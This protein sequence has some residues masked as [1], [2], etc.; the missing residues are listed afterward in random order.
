[1]GLG[2]RELSMNPGSIPKVKD[3]ISHLRMDAAESLAVR[4]LQADSA[5]SARA[6]AQERFPTNS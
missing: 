1:M 4:V 2:V 6:L 3:M 5:T